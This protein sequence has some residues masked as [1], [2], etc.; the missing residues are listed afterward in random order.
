LQKDQRDCIK[1]WETSQLWWPTPE[2]P[3]CLW[4]HCLGYDSFRWPCLKPHKITPPTATVDRKAEILS[5]VW[6]EHLPHP[7]KLVSTCVWP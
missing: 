2:P 7:P 4:W 5:Q 6:E 3:L 1:V